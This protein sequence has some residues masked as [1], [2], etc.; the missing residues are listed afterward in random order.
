MAGTRGVPKAWGLDTAVPRAPL[1]S[2]QVPGPAA[3]VCRP[4]SRGQAPTGAPAGR[5]A[6]VQGRPQGP[7]GRTALRP[8]RGGASQPNKLIPAEEQ[9]GTAGNGPGLLQLR[10][11]RHRSLEP[12][13]TAAPRTC[14]VPKPRAGHTQLAPHSPQH[15][16]GAATAQAQAPGTRRRLWAGGE[17][18]LPTRHQSGWNPG[19]VWGRAPASSLARQLRKPGAAAPSGWRLQVGGGAPGEGARAGRARAGTGGA[20]G[21]G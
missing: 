16:R 15:L 6:G 14:P 19:S 20:Q 7:R 12:R 2:S 8:Q 11:R 3:Q 10:V 21:T 9:W 18:A 1:P 4:H 17:A 5:L 13:C